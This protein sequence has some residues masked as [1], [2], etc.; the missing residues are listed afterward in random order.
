MPSPARAAFTPERVGGGAVGGT[1]LDR[2]SGKAPTPSSAKPKGVAS[3]FR[4]LL[5]KP[6]RQLSRSGV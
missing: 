5:F 6:R 1:V 4:S 2:L 3:A